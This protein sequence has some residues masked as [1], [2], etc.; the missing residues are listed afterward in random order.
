M[1]DKVD[2]KGK[3][4]ILQDKDY[5]DDMDLIIGTMSKEGAM[6]PEFVEYHKETCLYYGIP[7]YLGKDQELKKIYE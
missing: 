1:L 7:A 5:L 6:E 2:Y 4:F 3:Y